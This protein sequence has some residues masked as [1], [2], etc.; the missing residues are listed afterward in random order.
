M[1]ESQNDVK[2]LTSAEALARLSVVSLI[3]LIGFF[4]TILL[5]RWGP[6]WFTGTSKAEWQR[7]C[8]RGAYICGGVGLLAL[9]VMLILGSLFSLA[10]NWPEKV[11]SAVFVLNTIFFAFGM[12]RTGGAA[13]SFFGY[14]VPLQ[15]SGIL[16]LEQQK[17]MMTNTQLTTWTFAAFSTF[18]WLAA[19]LLRKQLAR[20]LQWQEFLMEPGLEKFTAFA[21]TLLFVLS[22]AVTVLAYWLPPRPEFIEFIRRHR[23]G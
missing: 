7:D 8:L 2:V 21:A 17:A 1:L 12:A 6:R 14:L 10:A 16:V 23:P 3:Q 18:I 5:V 9:F 15:L 4:M 20:R 22:V 19:V 11:I 13:Y